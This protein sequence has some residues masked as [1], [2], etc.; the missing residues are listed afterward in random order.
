M[1][2]EQMEASRAMAKNTAPAR[3]NR[4]WLGSCSLFLLS[5]S[6]SPLVV[7][8]PPPL[9]S[10]SC[11]RNGINNMPLDSTAFSSSPLSYIDLEVG[12]RHD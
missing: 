7:V 1:L 4:S 2:L 11:S 12:L 9:L 5:L 3:M 6:S 8:A 10:S